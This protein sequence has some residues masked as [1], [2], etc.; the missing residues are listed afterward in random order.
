[1]IWQVLFSKKI[2]G[3][4]LYQNIKKLEFFCFFLKKSH[5]PWGR[6]FL[7]YLI[8]KIS[9]TWKKRWRILAI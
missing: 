9:T 6:P 3:D 5:W 8:G 1:M 4:V 7:R 2:V